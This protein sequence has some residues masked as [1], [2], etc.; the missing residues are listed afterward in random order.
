MKSIKRNNSMIIIFSLCVAVVVTAMLGSTNSRA[1]D[2]DVYM[3]SVKNSAMVVFDNS[4]SMSWPVFEPTYDFANFMKWMRDPNGDGDTSDSLAD[5]DQTS[6]CTHWW[7]AHALEAEYYDEMS[8]VVTGTTSDTCGGEYVYD[9]DHNDWIKFS[10][11]DFGT[12]G[13]TKFEHGLNV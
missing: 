2:V 10:Q 7:D 8:G 11:V 6:R 3:T 12:D 1:D 9:L 5:D 13:M 4:G